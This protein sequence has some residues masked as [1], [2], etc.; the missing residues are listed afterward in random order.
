VTQYLAEH[1]QDEPVIIEVARPSASL[2]VVYP[3]INESDSIK[4]ILDAGSQIVSMSKDMAA[5]LN[6]TWNLDV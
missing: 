2:K 4:S 5:Q 3:V 1:S 6:I